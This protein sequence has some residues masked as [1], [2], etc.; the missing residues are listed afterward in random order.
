MFIVEP[1]D[2]VLRNLPVL[3]YSSSGNINIH[4]GVKK[5]SGNPEPGASVFLAI[6]YQL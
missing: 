4:K 5:K 3:L 1:V 2:Q 6:Q